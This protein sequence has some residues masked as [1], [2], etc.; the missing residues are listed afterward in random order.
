[1]EKTE[2][3]EVVSGKSSYHCFYL[4]KITP[5]GRGG[6]SSPQ[7]GKFMKYLDIRP[8]LPLPDLRTPSPVSE[9][10]SKSSGNSSH[11]VVYDPATKTFVQTYKTENP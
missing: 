10:V 2:E 5:M 1:L 3:R 4:I 8:F 6:C 11:Y 7:N 9:T